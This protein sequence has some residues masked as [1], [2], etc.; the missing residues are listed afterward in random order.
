LLDWDGLRHDD[1]IRGVDAAELAP[2]PVAVG[3]ED[4]LTL[5]GTGPRER[6]R[7]ANDPSDAFDARNGWKGGEGAVFALQN[8]Q[9]GWVD[10]GEF[11]FHPHLAPGGRGDFQF[12]VIDGFPW[13]AKL[14]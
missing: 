14:P 3:E 9:I 1:Q 7:L 10:G 11:Q 2:S 6:W 4:P 13:G 12:S 8:V 5:E